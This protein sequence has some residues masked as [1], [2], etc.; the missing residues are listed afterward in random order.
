MVYLKCAKCDSPVVYWGVTAADWLCSEH[1]PEEPKVDDESK[2]CLFC[3]KPMG[4]AVND[5]ESLQPNGGGEVRFIFSFGSAEF[6]EN[7]HS[8]VFK[9]LVCDECGKRYVP[10]MQKHS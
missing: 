4:C 5:W 7:V 8:T 1:R 10:Q 3:G 9:A 2:P 6:D